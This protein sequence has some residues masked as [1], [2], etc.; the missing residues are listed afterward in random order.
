MD[1]SKG[2]TRERGRFSLGGLRGVVIILA[3]EIVIFSVLTLRQGEGGFA[4]PYWSSRNLKNTA[5]AMSFF[6]LLAV[7]EALVIL[8][9][10]IDLSVGSLL[11]W[12]M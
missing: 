5:L 10:G 9:G 11:P 3:V 2:A 7:G 1:T 8:S 4:S 12:A 6:G